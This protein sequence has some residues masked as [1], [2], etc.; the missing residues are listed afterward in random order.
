MSLLSF[1]YIYSNW[2]EEYF[3]ICG[4][5][6]CTYFLRNK[7]LKMDCKM[8]AWC[9]YCALRNTSLSK[10]QINFTPAIVNYIEYSEIS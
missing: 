1:L 8:E 4:Q 2:L 9:V 7:S 6:R 3:F 5:T 10:V